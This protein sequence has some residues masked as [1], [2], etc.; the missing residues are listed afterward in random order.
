VPDVLRSLRLSARERR[1]GLFALAVVFYF[2]WWIWWNDERAHKLWADGYYNYLYARSLVFDHDIDFANDYKLCGDPQGDVHRLY[3]SSHA[4]NGAFI[5]SSIY[6]VPALL[7]SKLLVH[8]P[9]GA[10]QQ[11]VLGCEG[12]LVQ[13]TLFV[14]PICGAFTLWFGYLAARR[15]VGDGPAAAAAVVFGLGSTLTAFAAQNPCYTHT[16]EAFSA[17]VA[18]WLAT[19]AEA[20]PKKHAYWLLSG[21]FCGFSL[22]ARPNCVVMAMVP[23]ALALHVFWG[24][25]RDLAIAWA[26]ILVGLTLFGMLPLAEVN[27]FIFDRFSPFAARDKH[28]LQFKHPHEWLLLFSPIGGLF[29]FT[30]AAWFAMFGAPVGLLRDRA[31]GMAI[32][33]IGCTIPM[34]FICACVMDWH[35]ANSFGARRLTPLVPL[36][37][38]MGA[39]FFDGMSNWL[40]ARPARA[41]TLLAFAVL[42]PFCMSVTGLVAG[43][44]SNRTNW[45]DHALS[46][47]E[48]YGGGAS[49]MWFYLDHGYG[50][51]AVLPAEMYYSWRF[52]RPMTSFRDACR[53]WY[54]RHTRLWYWKPNLPNLNEGKIRSL[55]DGLAEGGG[56][57]RMVADRARVVLTTEWP[58]ATS[59]TLKATSAKPAHL[60]VGDGHVFGRSVWFGEMDLPGDG[61]EVS[62]TFTVPVGE[63]ES[64][65]NEFLF[66]SPGAEANGVVLKDWSLDDTTKYPP[67]YPPLRDL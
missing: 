1:W 57:T 59:Y 2:Y 53:Y 38:V 26:L 47:E 46:Q 22:L 11:V 10:S 41:L 45:W 32:G 27:K 54:S 3:F 14:G 7:L 12:P 21:M 55:E 36:F 17:S 67:M 61:K 16:Y 66:D 65:M 64:G 43:I 34:V 6:F 24:K 28:Q 5:G 15:Y 35:G 49:T 9:A 20:E 13:W 33:F 56:G 19:K 37:V 40:R 50:D 62:Q 23:A 31:R 48:V 4:W 25:W 44:R 60:R 8:L 29:F 18:I 51:L 42:T 58:I 30:P 52:N 39:V 63:L